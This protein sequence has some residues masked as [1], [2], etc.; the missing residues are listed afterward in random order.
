[1][2]PTALFGICAFFVVP[3]LS[4]L[5]EDTS[6]VTVVSSKIDGHYLRTKLPD[7]SFQTEFYAF[8]DGGRMSGTVR[9]GSIDDLPFMDVARTIAGPLQSQNFLPTRDPK[10]TK[11]LVVVYYGRTRTPEHASESVITQDVQGAAADFAAKKSQ[12]QHQ[13]YNDSTGLAAGSMMPCMR[14]SATPAPDTAGADNAL[15]GALASAAAADKSRD[16]SDAQ[17][18]SLLGYE[19]W[20]DA[21]ANYKGTPLEQRRQDMIE[22][23]EHDRY[24]VVLMAYDFQAM[25]KQKK[26]ILLW[27]T[28]FSVKQRG[29]D[30]DKQLTAIAKS[31]SQYFGQDTHGLVRKDLPVGSVEIG[32]IKQLGIVAQK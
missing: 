31:A 8:A 6:L 15:S 13:F 14:Y 1:M 28:R 29:V 25:W 32:D 27:E 9:D 24:F 18:A 17:N 7:G 19:S 3:S 23:L 2:K 21:T 26:H 20:W 12:D 22:E 16:E 10:A 11:L 4:G 5:A 30:F